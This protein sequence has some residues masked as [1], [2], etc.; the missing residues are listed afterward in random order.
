MELMP[1]EEDRACVSV[2]YPRAD[3]LGLTEVRA[4][5]AGL[6][7]MGPFSDVLP[8]PTAPYTII[9]FPFLFAV[10]FGDVG[11]G[12]LMF[13]FALWMVVY[14]NSPR[15]RQAQNEVRLGARH[16]GGGQVDWCHEGGVG[17]V[18]AA[19]QRPVLGRVGV[20]ESVWPGL[21]PDLMGG[22]VL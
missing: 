12:L 6:C 13:L 16:G 4:L 9:T 14:E 8:V 18:G 21:G 10:M 15:L 17:C 11:H 19:L 22:C 20:R 1:P 2:L 7:Q 5:L 3:R